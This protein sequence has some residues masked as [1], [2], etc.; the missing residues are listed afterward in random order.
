[1]ITKE[2]NAQFMR[3]MMESCYTY[4]GID[5]EGYNYERYILP[6]LDK[7]GKRTFNKIYNEKAEELSR[8]EIIRN[9]YTDSE[10]LTYN[11]LK[12]PVK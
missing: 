8:C 11:T 2:E 7:L 9:T 1:M 6:Y 4:G 3:E 5:P 10:G 12:K